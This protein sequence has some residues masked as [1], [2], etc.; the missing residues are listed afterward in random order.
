[1]GA[2]C[3]TS[4]S[5]SRSLSVA[6][7]QRRRRAAPSGRATLA[8][9]A[10]TARVSI[11]SASRALAR[12]ELVSEALRARVRAVAGELSYIPGGFGSVVATGWQRG[13][14]AVVAHLDDDLT[15]AAVAAMARELARM[16]KALILAIS[17]GTPEVTTARIADLLARGAGSIAFCG[18]PAIVMPQLHTT[19]APVG[20][21]SLDGA[22]AP[23]ASVAQAFS[24]TQALALG[25]LYLRE[26]GHVRVALLDMLDS[27][28]TRAV[29]EQAVV[30]GLQVVEAATSR[31]DDAAA[32]AAMLE[33]WRSQDPRIT[34]VVCGSDRVA[35]RLL[36][37]CLHNGIAVPHELAV[38]GFGDT[39]LSRQTR[40]ALTSLRISAVEAGVALAACLIASLE[41][42]SAGVAPLKAKLVVREST[43]PA[44]L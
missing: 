4:L 13:V 15:A 7:P 37:A 14:G 38:I 29:Q 6:S 11:A 23:D 3:R 28:T 43:A 12:P 21:A 34:G 18:T 16:D 25:V 1:M 39:E 2:A 31:H 32:L 44:P 26:L 19:A 42:R 41:G 9:V 17:D 10:R 35:A 40:P 33:R 5:D 8:D 22:A 20:F 30:H 27:A 36:Y 24:R